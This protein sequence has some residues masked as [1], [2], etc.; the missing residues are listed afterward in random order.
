MEKVCI[1]PACG[2]SFGRTKYPSGRL[3]PLV[4][5][6]KRKYCSL[7]CYGL[8]HRGENHHRWKGSLACKVCKRERARKYYPLSECEVCGQPATDHHHR[9]GDLDNNEPG[10]VQC[11]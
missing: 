2:R 1:Y 9:D 7:A 11:L 4:V 3:Q 5:F 6:A 8:A 10:N